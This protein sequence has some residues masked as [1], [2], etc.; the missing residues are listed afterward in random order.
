ME[1][2]DHTEDVDSEML[3]VILEDRDWEE[4]YEMEIHL[5]VGDMAFQWSKLWKSSA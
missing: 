2:R 4:Q 5:Q 3:D 1:V